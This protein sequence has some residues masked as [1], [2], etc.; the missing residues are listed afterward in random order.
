MPAVWARP[1]MLPHSIGDTGEIVYSAPD[2]ENAL[3][4]ALRLQ[5][6]GRYQFF[7][8]QE[9]SN[10]LPYPSLVRVPEHCIDAVKRRV[11]Q[12]MAYTRK[13][14]QVTGLHYSTDDL[15]AIAQHYGLPTNLLDMTTD[16]HCRNDVCM[17]PPIVS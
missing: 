15:W 12:F 10:W 17:P 8:G 16:P 13:V 11:S 7:R 3:S 9:N 5:Q 6:E 4:F 1:N 14:S 2:L